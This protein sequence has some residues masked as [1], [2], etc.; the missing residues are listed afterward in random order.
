MNQQENSHIDHADELPTEVRQV[1]QPE[2]DRLGVFRESVSSAVMAGTARAA[3]PATLPL[4]GKKAASGALGLGSILKD[5][6]ILEE[7]IGAGGMGVVFK[8]KDLRRVEAKDRNP[9]VAVKVLA[10]DLRV[11]PEAWIVL[12]R[13]ARKAQTLAHPNIITVFDFDQDADLGFITM[14]LLEG[15]SLAAVLGRVQGKGLKLV[16]ALPLIKGMGEAL[17][18]AHRKGIVHSDLKPGNVFVTREGIV[19]ILDF[20]VARAMRRSGDATGFDHTTV[21]DPSAVGAL[22]PAYATCEVIEGGPP[23]PRDDIYALACIVYELLRGEHPFHR[24]TGVQVRALDL[25]PKEIAGLNYSQ[26]RALQ[27]GL[28]IDRKRRTPSVEVF[29]SELEQGETKKS[30]VPKNWSYILWAGLIIVIGSGSYVVAPHFMNYMERRHV[31]ERF[32]ELAALLNAGQWTAE[33]LATGA[34]L[35]QQT[36]ESALQDVRLKDARDL[37]ASGY[38]ELARRALAEGGWDAAERLV[39]AG[40]ALTPGDRMDVELGGISTAIRNARLRQQEVLYLER[41]LEE[42]LAGMEPTAAAAKEVLAMVDAIG[43]L[44]P[45]HPGLEE[46]RAEVADKLATAAAAFGQAGNWPHGIALMNESLVLLPNSQALG[47]TKADLERAYAIKLGEARR[48][49]EEARR[50]AETQR[51]TGSARQVTV[52]KPPVPPK[53]VPEEQ[54]AGQQPTWVIKASEEEAQRTADVQQPAEAL[55]P[56]TPPE[57]PEIELIGRSIPPPAVQPPPAPPKP[58]PEEQP[59]GQQPTWVITPGG[60]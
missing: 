39:T 22:T 26:Q 59:A 16:E 55:K 41:R 7:Y 36:A 42:S 34:S 46:K 44:D 57:L 43:S 32:A 3:T 24:L 50:K 11:N 30:H 28:A 47:R 40:K 14:E 1:K 4:H 60:K 56:V 2:L 48:L 37:L 45:Q 27:R 12:Q 29:L 17:A 5:R 51:Q 31:D 18:Y 20:G 19:K 13:E 58:A 54:P 9:Y 25:K 35:L 33:R 38:A 10:E 53:S 21:F 23:D 8:A 49:K 52:R 15:E 6:F